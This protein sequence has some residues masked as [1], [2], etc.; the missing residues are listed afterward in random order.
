[1]DSAGGVGG[2]PLVVLADVD[3]LT[4]LAG[5]AEP[6]VFSDIDFVNALFGILHQRQKAGAVVLHAST[7]RIFA[8]TAA[9][10]SSIR[11]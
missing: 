10:F 1:M 5:F 3:Q 6:L 8:P 11:S 4:G 7:R 9:N 2:A